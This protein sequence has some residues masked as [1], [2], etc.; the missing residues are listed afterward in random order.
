MVIVV[1]YQAERMVGEGG[2]DGD[3]VGMGI[4]TGRGGRWWDTSGED[5]S[6]G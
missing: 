1:I 6:T 4:G 5:Y 2:G 3:E